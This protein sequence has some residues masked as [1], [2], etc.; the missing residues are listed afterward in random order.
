MPQHDNSALNVR[1]KMTHMRH[2]TDDETI[3][4]IQAS[5]S[6]EKSLPGT[7]ERWDWD[8][9]SGNDEPKTLRHATEAPTK[10]T[11]EDHH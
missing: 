7:Q 4:G 10:D 3:Y 1:I 11:S 6:R 9:E 8:N 2:E 5:N